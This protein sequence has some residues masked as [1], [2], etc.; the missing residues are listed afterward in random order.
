VLEEQILPLYYE[1]PAKW[2]KMMRNAIS[3]NAPLYNSEV[4]VKKYWREI[5]D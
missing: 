5:Y 1:Q 3:Y 4:M 2:L